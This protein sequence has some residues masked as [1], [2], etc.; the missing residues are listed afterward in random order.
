VQVAFAANKIETAELISKKTGQRTV[1]REMRT[2]TGSRFALWLPHVIASEGESQRP[3]LTPDEVMRLPHGKDEDPHDP[4]DALI[5]VSGF[6]PIHG[7]KIRYY[8]DAEFRRRAAVP[9]PVTS[10]RIPHDW[11]YWLTH[12]AV[13]GNPE[14]K[15]PEPPPPEREHAVQREHGDLF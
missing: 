12:Q 14:A 2:Y 10:D 5:F 15:K 4:G 1:H 7:K 9:A 6:P 13:L 3:L 8:H 11:S